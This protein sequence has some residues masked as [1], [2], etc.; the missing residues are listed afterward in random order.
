MP[1]ERTPAASYDLVVFCH[2]RWDF[3]YQ[4]PQHLI[5][6]LSKHY[7]TLFVEEPW[8]RPDRTE[9]AVR[10]VSDRLTVLQ[11][12]TDRIEEVGASVLDHLG[13]SAVST[14]WMYSP[15]FLPALDALTTDTLVYD[16]MDELS[17][18]RGAPPALVAQEQQLLARAD[19]VFTGGRSLYEAKQPYHDRV[20]CFPS[21][22]DREH[23]ARALDPSLSLPEAIAHIPTPIVG[24]FG[25]I[26]ER[27][28]LRLLD[29]TAALRPSVHFVM[30]GPLAKI[31]EGDLPR[32]ANIHYL[33]MRDY[34]DLPQY[35]RAF[36]VA[37]MPFALNDATKFISPTKTLE[38]MAAGKPIISTAVRDV[39]REYADTV[40]IVATAEA[41]AQAI[42]AAL[43]PG[44]QAP[45]YQAI[46]DR[47]SWDATAERMQSILEKI[48]A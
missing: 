27:V 39:V 40:A 45:D 36:A 17:L 43:S 22:V 21:S 14:V 9:H 44:A 16:C 29:D 23:F 7:R 41:F 25:V 3:V 10:A 15:S 4:R 38:Y 24:Y 34:A 32:R 37:M 5:S 47:T 33:G 1:T 42:D 31:G 13:G 48:P 8:H 35:L 12:N 28:D 46:L 2:L 18:F 19:V 20:Y 26:D 6:R 11:P 30:I